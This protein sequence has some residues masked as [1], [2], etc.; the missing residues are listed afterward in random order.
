MLES[1]AEQGSAHETYFP[2]DAP[3]SLSIIVLSKPCMAKVEFLWWCGESLPL[4]VNPPRIVGSFSRVFTVIRAILTTATARYNYISKLGSRTGTKR[5]SDG[6][7]NI[8]P[9]TLISIPTVKRG[10]GLQPHC[11]LPQSLKHIFYFLVDIKLLYY[12]CAIPL[13]KRSATWQ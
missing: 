5:G 7:R 1:G 10:G 3:W 4:S 6:P 9:Q 11:N 12:F 2:L 13:Q 8:D